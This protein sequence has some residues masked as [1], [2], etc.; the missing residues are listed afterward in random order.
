MGSVV[1]GVI[2]R[3]FNLS[4][5]QND[6]FIHLNHL[7]PYWNQQINV[8]SRKDIDQIEEHHF[9]HS[10][11]IAKII[12]FKDGSQVLDIGTGGGFPGIP[13]AIL[14]PKVEFTLVDSIA[15][16]IK[17]VQNIALELGLENVIPKVSRAKIS[18][19]IPNMIL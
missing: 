13:L 2:S 19:L 15:K 12:Q 10:L 17:V 16:K 9:L 8:I 7:Y 11:S 5:R 1:N 6:C 18:P 4:P 3:Y 14:F